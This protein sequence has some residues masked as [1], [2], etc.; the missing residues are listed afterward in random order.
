MEVVGKTIIK[1]PMRYFIFFPFPLRVGG[2]GKMVSRPKKLAAT[3]CQNRSQERKRRCVWQ[4]FTVAATKIIIPPFSNP[5]MAFSRGLNGV[6]RSGQN[7]VSNN[8]MGRGWKWQV[9]TSQNEQWH[10][11][12][13]GYLK[14]LFDVASSKAHQIQDTFFHRMKRR[15]S[16]QKSILFSSICFVWVP[17]A[18]FY[19]QKASLTC[20]LFTDTAGS[21]Q[22]Q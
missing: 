7:V 5:V 1:V 4:R 10:S 18:E 19:V 9:E 13:T 22:T 17:H 6:T 20:A 21:P 16:D 2:F 11:P 12:D 3:A 14:L 8:K 15:C